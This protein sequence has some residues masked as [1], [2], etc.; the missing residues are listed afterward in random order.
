VLSWSRFNNDTDTHQPVGI[1]SAVRDRRAQM[2]GELTTAQY[3]AVTIRSIHADHP[4]WNAPVRAYF[5]KEAGGWT[6]V[7]IDRP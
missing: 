5:R 1:E 6:N 7:G 4:A 3:V 2:P